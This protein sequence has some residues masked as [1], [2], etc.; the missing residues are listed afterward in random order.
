M[1]SRFLN[2]KPTHPQVITLENTDE[3]MSKK[4]IELKTLHA[5]SHENIVQFH[6]AFFIAGQLYFILVPFRYPSHSQEFMDKGTI[7]DLIQKTGPVPEPVLGKLSHD[8][9]CGLE[10]LHKT[11]HLIH[12]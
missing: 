12:R 3:F 5:S 2:S 10:Y 8:V 7:A 11:L 4:L 1:L 6:G 9:L